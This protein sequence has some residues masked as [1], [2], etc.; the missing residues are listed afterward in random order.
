MRVDLGVWNLAR[1]SRIRIGPRPG[2]RVQ[3]IPSEC[4]AFS[5]SDARPD[6]TLASVRATA[7]EA[8]PFG[9]LLRWDEFD[10]I[11]VQAQ[12]RDEPRIVALPLVVDASGHHLASNVSACR[13][14]DADQRVVT[15]PEDRIDRGHRVD[16]VADQQVPRSAD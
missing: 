14:A 13:L 7:E 2:F 3:G 16:A 6:A 8:I 1:L 5:K 12:A 4:G 9:K 10:R 15:A 11:P